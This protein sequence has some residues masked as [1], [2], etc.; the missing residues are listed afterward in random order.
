MIFSCVLFAAWV[1][2]VFVKYQEGKGKKENKK[3]KRKGGEENK[4]NWEDR[5]GEGEDIGGKET[6]GWGRYLV[7][8]P[9]L[10]VVHSHPIVRSLSHSFFHIYMHAHTQNISFVNNID[11]IN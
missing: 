2:F 8:Q 9:Q 3:D 5:L 1:S 11:Q 7:P 4:G 10:R 6:I